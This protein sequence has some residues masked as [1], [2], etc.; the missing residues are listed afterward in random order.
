MGPN[1]GLYGVNLTPNPTVYTNSMGQNVQM[2]HSGLPG[3]PPTF[4]V[5]TDDL[6]MNQ[7]IVPPQGPRPQRGVTLRRNRFNPKSVGEPSE[8]PNVDPNMRITVI[9]GA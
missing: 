3:A 5:P 6:T 8:K 4:S 7:Y 1:F 2:F 9:K